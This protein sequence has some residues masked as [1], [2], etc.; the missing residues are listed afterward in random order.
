MPAPLMSSPA[1]AAIPIGIAAFGAIRRGHALKRA[2][3]LAVT[4]LLLLGMGVSVVIPAMA[5]HSCPD[6][7]SCSA[8][9][10]H[11]RDARDNGHSDGAKGHHHYHLDS[12]AHHLGIADGP[13]MLGVRLVV[14]DVER[15]AFETHAIGASPDA[16]FRPPR[17]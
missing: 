6:H 15:L 16:A 17:S 9:R 2:L 13:A 8:V 12:H 5:A 7:I 3:R 11:A 10:H 1:A 4:L 14:E